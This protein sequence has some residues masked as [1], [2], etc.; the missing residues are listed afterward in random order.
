MTAIAIVLAVAIAII[1]TRRTAARG[2]SREQFADHM[3]PAMTAFLETQRLRKEEKTHPSLHV[4]IFD[5]L[6]ASGH[7]MPTD[8]AV[9]HY[10]SIARR[11]SMNDQEICAK[12]L[13]DAAL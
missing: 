5:C 4:R 6:R 13:R 8:A 2:H 3:R 10:A 1:V 9:K 12:I 7:E 11:H